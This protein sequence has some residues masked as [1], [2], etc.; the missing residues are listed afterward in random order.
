MILHWKLC[1]SV[2]PFEWY[3]LN[4]YHLMESWWKTS[5]SKKTQKHV[6]CALSLNISY[7][8]HFF[9]REKILVALETYAKKMNPPSIVLGGGVH[10]KS[11]WLIAYYTRY[12]YFVST[13]GGRATLSCPPLHLLELIKNFTGKDYNFSKKRHILAQKWSPPFLGTS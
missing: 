5:F 3:N 9:F 13:R 8:I 4:V 6:F 2:R 12:T 1:S 11:C 10:G 7:K